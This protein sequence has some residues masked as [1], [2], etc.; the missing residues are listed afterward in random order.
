MVIFFS[1]KNYIFKPSLFFHNLSRMAKTRVH[2]FVSGRVQGVF[3]RQST[4]RQAK[5]LGVKGWV[6][7]LQDRRVEAVFEGESLAV[8]SLVDYCRQGPATSRV[9]NVDVLVE[10]YQG[11]FKDFEAI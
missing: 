11:E 3:F 10:G 2:I 7:N 1:F 4:Q 6:R 5:N 9:D 8:N